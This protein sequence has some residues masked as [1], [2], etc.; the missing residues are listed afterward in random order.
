ME[1]SPRPHRSLAEQIS[2]EE[3]EKETATAEVPVAQTSGEEEKL[4]EDGKR[5]K[6]K[7]Q[8][9]AADDK[10]PPAVVEEACGANGIPC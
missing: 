3:N 8:Y 4:T 1:K 6:Q 7:Q 5:C 9:T 2:K 10:I